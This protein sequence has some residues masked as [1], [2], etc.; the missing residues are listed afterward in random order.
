MT[1]QSVKLG[2]AAVIKALKAHSRSKI[3]RAS[4]EAQGA[5]LEHE[6]DRG[7]VIMTAAMIEDTLNQALENRLGHLNRKEL[8]A[9]FEF[10]GPM[11]TFSAKIKSAQAFKIIDRATRNHI[12]MIREM[13]NA[14]AHSQNGL[15]FKDEI[16][17]NAVFSMLTPNAA[18][19]YKDDEKH[20]RVAFVIM[21]GVIA[22]IIVA[23]DVQKGTAKV[24]AIIEQVITEHKAPSNT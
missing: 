15:T 21:T 17:R 23:G 22:N 5:S 10:N 3:T 8:D 13:R 24:N 11:G 16:L 19:S 1:V 14:C 12:E 20:I 18:E 9:L 7:T 6:S 2:R 4:I